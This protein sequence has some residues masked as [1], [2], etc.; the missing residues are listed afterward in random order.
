M[1]K[2][3]MVAGKLAVGRCVGSDVVLGRWRV[4]AGWEVD[5]GDG[6]EG[7]LARDRRV[8]I[9]RGGGDWVG[10][11][12]WRLGVGVGGEGLALAGGG[13]VVVV[14]EGLRGW[15]RGRWWWVVLKRLGERAGRSSGDGGGVGR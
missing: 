12:S 3:E 8:E 11:R 5:G 2:R 14:V 15:V 6:A 9:G 4:G 10:G 13:F 7:L 1:V